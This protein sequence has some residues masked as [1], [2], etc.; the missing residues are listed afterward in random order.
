M[1]YQRTEMLFEK[2]LPVFVGVDRRFMVFEVAPSRGM[3]HFHCFAYRTDDRP[4]S[5]LPAE[6]KEGLR[7]FFEENGFT[8]HLEGDYDTPEWPEKE[9]TRKAAQMFEDSKVL[10]SPGTA[11]DYDDPVKRGAFIRSV[12]MHFCSRYCSPGTAWECRFGFGDAVAVHRKAVV[13]AATEAA[14][15]VARDVV[16]DAVP[17]P[18]RLATKKKKARPHLSFSVRRNSTMILS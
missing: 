6:G 11:L 18:V 16:D 4:H 5:V 3:V 10:R 15:E 12:L 17:S 13:L 14:A 7:R 2:V 9:V 1:F 8:C